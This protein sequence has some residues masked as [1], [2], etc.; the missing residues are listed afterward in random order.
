MIKKFLF[1]VT[2]LILALPLAAQPIPPHMQKHGNPPP[3]PCQFSEN[4]LDLRFLNLS[5]EQ[6][7]Q[8]NKITEEYRKKVDLTIVDLNRN[9]LD[10]D[11]MMINDNYD[12]NKLKELIEIRKKL[13]SDILVTFLERDLK[14]KD[15]LTKEQWNTFKKNFPKGVNFVDEKHIKDKRNEKRNFRAKQ[16]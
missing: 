8:I 12:F 14:V 4:D 11:E 16:L 5:E 6:N 9:K 2:V 15:L 1:P 3:P 7:A 10:F 13:E